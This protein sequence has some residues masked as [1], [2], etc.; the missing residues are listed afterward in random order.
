MEFENFKI[1]ETKAS[2]DRLN[3]RET[4]E[5]YWSHWK[6][7]IIC[8]V[9]SM[10]FAFLYLRYTKDSYLVSSTI[11]IEDKE[12]GGL[13]NELS[14]FND[15]G[16]IGNVPKKSIINEIG[17]LKSRT[18]LENVIKELKINNTFYSKGRF[19][20]YELYKQDI[21]LHINF[22][23]NDSLTDKLNVEFSVIVESEDTYSL[24]IG[25]DDVLIN[26][27]FGETVHASFGDIIINQS[28]TNSLDI[29]KSLI[30]KVEPLRKVAIRY[31]KKINISPESEGSS[32]LSLSLEDEVKDKAKDILNTL[33]QNYIQEGINYKIFIANNTDM[34]VN[35]RI[36]DISTDL[37]NVDKGVEEFKKKNKLTDLNLEAGIDLASNS[38]TQKIITDLNSE[39]KLVE[40]IIEHLN[41]NQESLIPSNLGLKDSKTNEN[42]NLY[43]QLLLERNRILKGSSSLNPTVINLESQILTLRTSIVQSLVN[44]KSSLE[45]SMN[46]AA[47]QQYKINT[48]RDA[49]PQQEREFQDIKRKQQ[50][51][52][53]LYLYLLQKRE[54]NALSLG[55][56]VPNA[57]IIDEA[58][59]SDVPIFPQPILIYVI[60]FFL[61]VICFIFIITIKN[62]LDTKIH[63]SDDIE[64]A[65]D[66][67]ILG[68]IPKSKLKN[69]LVFGETDSSGIAEAFRL[70][71]TNMAFMLNKND[72]SS[73]CIFVTSTI[74]SEGKTFISANLA[75]SIAAINKKVLIIGADIRKPKLEAYLNLE[76]STKGLTHYLRDEEIQPS[77]IINSNVF[78][79]FSLVNSGDIPPNPSELLLNGRFEKLLSYAKNNYD[80]VII[81]TS[82]VSM[83]T[84]TLLIADFSDLFIYVV[85]AEFL[86]KR[87]LKIADKL[88]RTKKLP[89][90]AMLLNGADFKKKGYGYGY[91]YGYDKKSWLKNIFA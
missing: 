29:G 3:I 12:A 62:I 13:P 37:T 51:I 85:R 60:S 70:L 27:R 88:Y 31:L 39:L 6:L 40:Y 46:E 56:P 44:L 17:I 86:D 38:E 14:V 58:A 19:V 23:L 79:N 76:T 45:F 25:K 63:S 50:I 91:G 73:K 16:I 72:K 24:V 5:R 74:G 20:N 54:E 64:R 65:M 67:P 30:V 22:V 82:P 59:G 87:F 42:A 84:D 26:M 34:F 47:G 36:K 78:D 75:L 81:D 28:R 55:I 33:V 10:V 77:D 57:K 61:G 21:P 48:K 35:E 18:A 7:F 68:E 66:V 9:I 43:N 4:L 41:N 2:N 53:S 69:K 8:L 90:M 52:E 89:N 11:F 49:A 80:Y 32:L 71:R 83:V 15:L 1:S